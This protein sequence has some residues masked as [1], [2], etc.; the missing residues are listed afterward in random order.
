[1]KKHKMGGAYPGNCSKPMQQYT[2][3]ASDFNAQGQAT[4][5]FV[6]YGGGNALVLQQNGVAQPQVG[7]KQ[8]QY[9]QGKIKLSSRDHIV[10]LNVV[11]NQQLQLTIYSWK[12]LTLIL[13]QSHSPKEY[14]RA[15]QS[16][17]KLLM[18]RSMKLSYRKA[19]D[20]DPPLLSNLPRKTKSRRKCR[21]NRL[22][23]NRRIPPHQWRHRLQQIPTTTM[24]LHP[25]STIL[26][27]YHPLLQQLFKHLMPVE[28]RR[29]I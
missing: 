1:M 8:P 22:P 21:T 3:A 26:I 24:D 19:L 5:H 14:T 25:D 16:T 29:L 18:E 6:S 23:N 12:F 17:Y 4:A 27:L 10:T 20:L 9:I 13:C 2:P 15:K 7:Q 28:K 11:F